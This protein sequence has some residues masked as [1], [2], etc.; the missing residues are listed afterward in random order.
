M[1]MFLE[2]GLSNALAAAVL[3]LLAGASRLARR[4]ALT[5]SLWLLVLLKLV[6]PP[7]VALSITW[8]GGTQATAIE[9]IKAG[10]SIEL[11][12][13][14]E[15]NAAPQPVFEEAVAENP[16]PHDLARK[17]DR[18]E[19]SSDPGSAI[20]PSGVPDTNSVRTA[21]ET[22]AVPWGLLL[23]HL[24]WAGSLVWFLLTTCMV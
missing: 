5:H 15:A 24:W 14:E 9:P 13:A 23:G 4:P 8:P 2:I 1:S 18:P 17:T 22:V 10:N 12:A 7:I 21:T 6:T 20:I 3:A 19:E 16:V 11:V